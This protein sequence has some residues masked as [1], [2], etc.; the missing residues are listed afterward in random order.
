MPLFFSGTIQRCDYAL[1]GLSPQIKTGLKELRFVNRQFKENV[2]LAVR[3]FSTQRD[4]K[5]TVNLHLKFPEMQNIPLE[6]YS[7][8]LRPFW[9][10]QESIR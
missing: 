5:K 10:L 4:D 3:A 1:K 6:K 9:K 8:C 2:K 7:T